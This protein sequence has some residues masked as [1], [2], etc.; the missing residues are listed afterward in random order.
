MLSRAER[1]VCGCSVVT[2]L[3]QDY[4]KNH[5]HV[6]RKHTGSWTSPERGTETRSSAQ[7]GKAVVTCE[8]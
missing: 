6:L 8:W 7:E 5:S 2:G 4:Y 3:L 1:G